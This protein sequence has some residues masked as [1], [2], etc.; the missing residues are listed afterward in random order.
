MFKAL[1]LTRSE[2]S[3]LQCELTELDESRLPEGEVLVQVAYS[4]LNYKDGLA[5]T[6][7]A[8]VV[9]SNDLSTFLLKFSKIMIED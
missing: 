8:P 9:A 5:I 7:K 2:D 4:T 3:P 1:L 6:G